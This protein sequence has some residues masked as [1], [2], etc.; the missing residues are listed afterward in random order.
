ML[1]FVLS[2]FAFV[3]FET[4]RDRNKRISFVLTSLGKI[5]EKR[6]NGTRNKRELLGSNLTKG[7]HQRSKG[8]VAETATKKI[9]Y[10]K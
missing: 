7:E 6:W 2:L 1:L 9:E 8:V 3:L 5:K 4:G 10:R